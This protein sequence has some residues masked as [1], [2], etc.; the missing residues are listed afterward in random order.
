MSAATGN[1]ARSDIGIMATPVV[2]SNVGA[3]EAIGTLLT[4]YG[5]N[6]FSIDPNRSS[7]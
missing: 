1:I 2:S 4:Y 6:M 5:R 7:F 3:G